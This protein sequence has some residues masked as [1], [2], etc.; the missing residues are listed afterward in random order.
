[1]KRF[2]KLTLIGAL[3]AVALVVASNVVGE[4][5]I[6]P[7]K[8]GTGSFIPAGVGLSVLYLGIIIGLPARLLTF[9]S[10]SLFASAAAAVIGFG[11]WGT[12]FAGIFQYL[13]RRLR[14]TTQKHAAPSNHD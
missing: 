13:A 2:A 5:L 11:L 3:G 9:G 8:Y 4:W 7:W 14:R 6:A 1:M 10:D 12:A